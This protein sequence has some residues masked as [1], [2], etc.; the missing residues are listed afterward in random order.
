MSSAPLVKKCD[1]TPKFQ[2]TDST[3]LAASAENIGNERFL[4]SE[5]CQICLPE[6][7]D[8]GPS[9]QLVTANRLATRGE[10]KLGGCTPLHRPS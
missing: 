9:G 1:A 10:G 3:N 8:V 5:I 6:E 4:E 7:E 2:R